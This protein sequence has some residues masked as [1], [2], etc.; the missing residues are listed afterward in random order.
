MLAFAVFVD[1]PQ[2]WQA[3]TPIGKMVAAIAGY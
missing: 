1:G 3:V 2:N